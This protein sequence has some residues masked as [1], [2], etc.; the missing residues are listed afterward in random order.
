MAFDSS[1]KA[2][3]GS[4]SIL[5][6]YDMPGWSNSTQVVDSGLNSTDLASCSSPPTITI[7]KYIAGGR[8]TATDQFRLTLRQGTQTIGEATT[9]GS[10]AGLQS[11]RIGPLPTVRNVPLT[12]TEVGAGSPAANLARYAS[13]YRC[14]VDG[15]LDPQASGSGTTGTITIPANGQAVVCQFH[16]SP[17][18]ATVNINKVE[19]DSEGLN[20]QPGGG[21]TVG[22]AASATTGN[23]TL[24]PAA[25]TQLT[26]AVTGSASWDVNFN[27]VTARATVEVWEVQ[28]SGYGFVDGQCTITPLGGEPGDPISLPDEDGTAI[29]GVAPGDT[30]DCT[31]TNKLSPT[32]LTLAK[33]VSFGDAEPTVW[34][35]QATGPSGSLPGP[36]G[37]TGSDPAS[38][39]VTPGVAYTLSESGGPDI[40]IQDGDWTCQTD[41]E[42]PVTVTESRVTLASGDDVTC[43]VNNATAL[44]TLLKHVED[45]ALDPGDWELTAEPD[46]V[47]GLDLGTETVAGADA[48]SDENTFHVR[49]NHSYTISEAL[50]SQTGVIAFRALGIEQLVD[51]EWVPVNSD[52]V[53]LEPGEHAT[54]RF[55]NDSLPEIRLP[56][57]GGLA[58]DAFLVGGA[59]VLLLAL[60]LAAVQRRR[61]NEVRL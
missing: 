21:W 50:A 23:A 8:V 38:A 32:N 18:V 52:E 34:T 5:R 42:E 53:E 41:S 20:P 31:F 15:V 25:E 61:R 47:T 24:D 35:L 59:G 1:G 29:P 9:T 28:Q 60:G 40:Y 43:T 45:P 58:S 19:L 54:Y 44:L 30:V 17:L 27:A 16:N 26:D 12:F 22:A 51:G 11:A 48:E 4:G 10:A 2:Y 37:T 7:E 55:V 49:P 6:S 57:T 39:E 14:E 56:L 36:N 33:E 3:L 13:S 46:Q